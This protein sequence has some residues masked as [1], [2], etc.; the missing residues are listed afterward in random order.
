[1]HSTLLLGERIMKQII[2]IAFTVVAM[3]S[4]AH[5]RF[6]GHYETKELRCNNGALSTAREDDSSPVISPKP[7]P[8]PIPAPVNATA[9]GENQ[10]KFPCTRTDGSIRTE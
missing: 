9:C 5:A 4:S 3:S 1:M 7:A 8:L 10:K 2:L 6:C